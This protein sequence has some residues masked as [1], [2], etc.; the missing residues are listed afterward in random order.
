MPPRLQFSV[1]SDQFLV[2]VSSPPASDGYQPVMRNLVDRVR[3]ARAGVIAV[4][5]E[6][7]SRQEEHHAQE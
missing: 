2:S 5:G 7:M 3:D 1:E 4:G 6:E